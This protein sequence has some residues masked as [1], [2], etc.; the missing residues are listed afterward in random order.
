MGHGCDSME[1]EHAWGMAVIACMGHGCD[2]VEHAWGMAVIA[3]SM[4]GAWL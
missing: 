3:W 1:Q 4:H 2:S